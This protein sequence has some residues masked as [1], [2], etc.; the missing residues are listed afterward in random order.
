MLSL[1]DDATHLG[2]RKRLEVLPNGDLSVQDDVAIEFVR[3]R[4]A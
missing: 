3:H 4:D 1:Q 2:I